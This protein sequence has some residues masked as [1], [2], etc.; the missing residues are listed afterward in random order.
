MPKAL[1]VTIAAV[2]LLAAVS[3]SRDWP[4]YG[5]GSESI[6]YSNLKQINR[7]NVSRLQVA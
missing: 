3:E 4:A 7:S 6:R 2:S 1:F 5:G